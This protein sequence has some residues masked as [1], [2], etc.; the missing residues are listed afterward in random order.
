MV[1]AYFYTY[2]EAMVELLHA[3][4]SVL[5]VYAFWYIGVVTTNNTWVQPCQVCVNAQGIAELSFLGYV[6]SAHYE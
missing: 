2:S 5:A 1:Q 3:I 4:F 6:F